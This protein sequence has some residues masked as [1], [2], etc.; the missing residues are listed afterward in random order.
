MRI[1][2]QPVTVPTGPRRWAPRATHP[3]M[4]DK[5]IRGVLIGA[6]ALAAGAAVAL[7]PLSIAVVAASIVGIWLV[8]IGRQSIAVFHG[9]LVGLLI[10]YAFLGKGF[11]YFGLPPLYVG[12]MCLALAVVAILYSVRQARF[13]LPLLLLVLFMAWG[14]VRT[15]PYIQTYGLFAIRDGVTWEYGIFAVAVALTVRHEHI[16]RVV[17]LYRRGALLLVWWMPVAAILTISFSGVVPKYPGSPVPFIFYKAGDAGVQLA[18]IAAFVLLGLYSVRDTA[19]MR[20]VVLWFGWF[21]SAGLAAL[22]RSA[23]LAMATTAACFL[24]VFS[25]PRVLS[26]AFVGSVFAVMLLTVNPEVDLGLGR[27]VSITQLVANL[28][29]ITGGDDAQLDASKDW[30]LAWW[31]KIYTYTVDG[32]YFWVGKGFGANLATEDGFQV[33]AQQSLRA[34]HSVHLEILARAGV[35]GLV[36]WALLQVAFAAAMLRAAATARRIKEPAWIPLLGWVFVYWLAALVNGSF[37][38]YLGGPQGGIW[39]WSMIGFGLALTRMV[40]ERATSAADSA[41]PATAAPVIVAGRPTRPPD[42]PRPVT[43]AER[44]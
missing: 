13:S 2:E 1:A 41:T 27:D 29:S 42:G 38:V 34:P 23:M 33:D 8:A 15:L 14:V 22:S 20:Q 25:I 9:A 31:T 10:G 17:A 30:R 3:E 16:D 12:E 43:S 36:L 35:P 28:G 5:V 11:A 18:A 39:F 7:S 32:P 24:F 44:A 40:S 6:L 4:R 19:P 37:D 21:I 26:L